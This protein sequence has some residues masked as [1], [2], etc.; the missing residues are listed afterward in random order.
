M[1][2]ITENSYYQFFDGFPRFRNEPPYVSSLLIEFRKRL[3]DKTLSEINMM[4]LD[5]NRSDDLGPG[6]GTDVTEEASAKKK[7]SGTII[8]DATCAPQNIS[9]PRMLTF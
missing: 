2:Q 9:Y 3:N 1:G 6:S 7:N 8:L 4:I 5:Y